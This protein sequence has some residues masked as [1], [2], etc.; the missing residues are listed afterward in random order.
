M[1]PSHSS[2]E[3]SALPTRQFG[4]AALMLIMLWLAAGLALMRIALPFGL[5]Y[6]F[7]TLPAVARTCRQV[8]QGK[9][10]GRL[11]RNTA[12]VSTFL[13]SVQMVVL[14]VIMSLTALLG[15]CAVTCVWCLQIAAQVSRVVGTILARF[16]RPVDQWTRW[17]FAVSGRFAA[18]FRVRRR[19]LISAPWRITALACSLA[20]ALALLG[21]LIVVGMARVL[22]DGLARTRHPLLSLRERFAKWT[23]AVVAADRRVLRTFRA[24]A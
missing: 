20:S 16:L 7:A 8:S 5:V 19:F 6:Y 14:L 13:H 23:A 18:G 10:A 11:I 3:P 4:L 2:A 9:R 22:C 12:L 17:T 1:S 15:G 24:A 21:S